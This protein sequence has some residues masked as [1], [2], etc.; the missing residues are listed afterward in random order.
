ML[1]DCFKNP[2]LLQ[3][4]SPGEGLVIQLRG[5]SV[6]LLTVSQ[7]APF[8]LEK[9]FKLHLVCSSLTSFIFKFN[10]GSLQQ[11]KREIGGF[12]LPK[13]GYDERDISQKFSSNL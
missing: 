12:F 5:N 4:L 6:N 1:Q 8:Q 10:K 13:G 7:E 9:L 2:R 11:Q 3:L